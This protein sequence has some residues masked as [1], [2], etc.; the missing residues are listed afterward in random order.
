MKNDLGKEDRLRAILKEDGMESPTESFSIRLSRMIVHQYIRRSEDTFKAGKWL[1]KLII[2]VLISFN[3][4]FLFYLGSSE[5]Q[6]VLF[7]SLTT[8]VLGVWGVIALSKTM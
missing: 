3:V 1:G 4:L 2:G 7:I 5:F 6:S 8:F